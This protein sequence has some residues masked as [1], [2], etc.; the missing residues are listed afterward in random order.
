MSK[1][2]IDLTEYRKSLKQMGYSIRTRANSSFITATITHDES[3]DVVTGYNVMSP[4][5]YEKHKSFFQF[6]E[7]VKVRD[8]KRMMTVI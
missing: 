6:R 2:E 8:H 7:S 1:S 5:K 3:G 4:E